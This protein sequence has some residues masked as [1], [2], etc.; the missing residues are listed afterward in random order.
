MLHRS[1]LTPRV[2]RM[3]VNFGNELVSHELI[4]PYPAQADASREQLRGRPRAKLSGILVSEP[5][6]HVWGQEAGHETAQVFCN[7][8]SVI[9]LT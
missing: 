7:K 2:L 8:V 4:P 9:W 3:K 5:V 1:D 6:G